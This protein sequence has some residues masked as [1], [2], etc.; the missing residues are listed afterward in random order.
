MRICGPHMQANQPSGNY[1]H[2]LQMTVREQARLINEIS[3]CY[4]HLVW[5]LNSSKFHTDTTVQVNDILR[6]TADISSAL[7]EAQNDKLVQKLTKPVVATGE[8]TSL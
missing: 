3:E 7:R 5:Y 1:I 2:Q 6:R 8:V 4:D